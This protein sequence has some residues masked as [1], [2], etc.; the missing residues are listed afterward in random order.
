[1]VA[2]EELNRAL[3]DELRGRVEAATPLRRLASVQD[4][5]LTV[6]WLCSPAAAYITGKII[7]IDGG[8]EAPTLPSD[9]PDL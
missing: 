3:D 7:D 6:R 4:V 5:A 2:T 8:A 1:M 9:A